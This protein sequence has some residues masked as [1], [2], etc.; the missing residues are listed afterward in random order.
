MSPHPWSLMTESRK[1]MRARGALLAK[2][3]LLAAEPE[4]LLSMNHDLMWK[5]Q[6]EHTEITLVKVEMQTLHG[7]RYHCVL[8]AEVGYTG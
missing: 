2:E 6:A 1:A 5:L 7:H 3:P 8:Q 4:E